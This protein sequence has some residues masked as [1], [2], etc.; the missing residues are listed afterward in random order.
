MF[1]V[2]SLERRDLHKAVAL[3]NEDS[4]SCLLLTAEA[5]ESVS[6]LK[7]EICLQHLRTPMR[8]HFQAGLG[9]VK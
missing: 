2:P 8:V 7:T 9:Q 4:D 1:G 5:Q 6:G 3:V